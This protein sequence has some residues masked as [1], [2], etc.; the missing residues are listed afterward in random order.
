[1]NKKKAVPAVGREPR[2][3]AACSRT[4]QA[5]DLPLIELPLDARA[6][7]GHVSQCGKG[8]GRKINVVLCTSHTTVNDP[9]LN[10][11]VTVRDSCSHGN[12]ALDSSGADAV[13]ETVTTN[14]GISA[15]GRLDGRHHEA[16]R[17]ECLTTGYERPADGVTILLGG[18]ARPVV[19]HEHRDSGSERVVI[20]DVTTCTETLTIV[21]HVPGVHLGEKIVSRIVDGFRKFLEVRVGGRS[22][23]GGWLRP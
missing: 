7:K 8:D 18:R 14:H 3:Q 9:D 13:D 20:V 10:A 22:D 12:V 11:L 6:S 2:L 4:N 1:M 5:V 17:V 15:N 23:G 16:S 21:G 19:E